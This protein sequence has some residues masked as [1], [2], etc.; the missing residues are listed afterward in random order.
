MK[1]DMAWPRD[2]AETR[3]SELFDAARTGGPQKVTD[4]DGT[5]CVTFTPKRRPLT[6]LFSA[7]GPISD[8]ADPEVQ[9]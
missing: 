9:P 3:I 2:V 5:F 1:H 6:E 4:N 7:P 8:D